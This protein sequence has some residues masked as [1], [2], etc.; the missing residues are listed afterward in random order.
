MFSSGLL[1]YELPTCE[2][3]TLHKTEP[4]PDPERDGYSPS[5]YLRVLDLEF[6]HSVWRNRDAPCLKFSLNLLQNPEYHSSFVVK[7]NEIE[8]TKL[9]EAYGGLPGLGAYVDGTYREMIGKVA[10]RALLDGYSKHLNESRDAVTA[11]IRR[12]SRLRPS[13]TLQVLASNV[14]ADV[15]IPA[16]ATELIAST[17]DHSKFY[18]DLSRFEPL[19]EWVSWDSL[20]E[21]FRSTVNR[22]ANILKQSTQSLRDHLT[23]FG[24]LLAATENIRTQ[25]SILWLTLL[26]AALTLVTILSSDAH[27]ELVRWLQDCGDTWVRGEDD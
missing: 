23:Q 11:R 16:V 18:R 12:P 10:I 26:V 5:G 25:N 14:A 27:S 15:D 7:D 13:R 2:L 9:L 19:Y 4:F 21:V 24:T 3:V 17:E 6:S 8:R 22:H 1:G 20:E